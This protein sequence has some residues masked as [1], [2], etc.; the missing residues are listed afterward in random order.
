[1]NIQISYNYVT[2]SESNLVTLSTCNQ[3]KLWRFGK[4]LIFAMI[5]TKIKMS[6]N[7]ENLKQHDERHS[8]SSLVNPFQIH[9]SQKEL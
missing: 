6:I 3:T 1:M 5:E 4:M 7:S 8:D 9:Y 2:I